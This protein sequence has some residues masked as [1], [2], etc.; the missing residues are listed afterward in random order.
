MLELA[1]EQIAMGQKAADKAEALRL[2][3]DRL[4]A[5]GLV[6]EGYLQGL[7]AREAQGSTFLGQ[8]IAIPHGTPQTRDLV[9]ATG[10]R[11]LQFPEGVDWGDGQMVYLAIGIAA[12]SDEHLRLLQLLTRALGETDLA[13]A[14]RRAGSAE[15]LLKLLQGAPQELALDAQL[16]GLNLA[17]EDFD[18]LAWRG[19]R[20]LQRA[21]C[22]DS[23][24][25]AVLQQAEPLPLGEG[26]WWLHSE[27]QVRQPGLAFITPQQPLRYRDQ[28]LNGLF[29]LASLGAAH[30][31]LLERLCEVLIEGRGQMLYQATSSRAVLEVLGGEA[32]ADWPS[33]RVVLANPHGLHARPAKVLAQLAKGFEGEIRVRLVDSAQ[34]A[35]SAKSLSKLLSLGARRGQALEL[36]AEPGIAADAL[37]VL[38]TAIEEGLG[39]EVEPLPQTAA[40]ADEVAE[41]LQAPGAGSR[42]QGV[43]AAPGIA[44]GPAHVCVEREFDYPLRGESCAQ[45][46]QK[47]REAV[48]TVNG[49]LQALIQR[50]DK[51]IGEIFIT[52]QEML[53]D[54]ALTDDVEQRLGQGESAAAAWMAVVEA[55]ARQQEA[56]HDALLA[57]RAADLRDIGRRVLAQ[58]CGVPAQAEPEQPYVL[59]MTEVGPSDVARLDPGRVAG[60]V[61]AQGGATAHSAIVARALG[62]PAVVGAGASILLLDNGT[63]LLLDGQRGVVSVAPP[64]DEL[65]RAL[66]ERDLREQRLQAAWA[67]RFE[68]AVT[69]DGHAVEVFANIGESNGIAKVV[70]QGA[71]GVGLL[72]TELIFMA[73]TQAP[74][75]ATQ[76]AE[77]RRVL[78]GLDG[79]PLV[80]RTLD[81][82]GD[83]PL[84][85]WPIAAEEN[86]FL[87]VRGVRLTLQRPQLMEDQLRALLRAAD[88]RPLRIMFPM[89]G[90]VHEWR[91]ARAM[92][93]RLRAEIPVA[94]LQL[95]IMVEVPSAALLAPQLAREVDF[96]SIGTNDLTQYTLAIDR[97]H[98]SL[99][100]QAD[101]L[102]PAVLSLIDMTVRAAH[103]HGKWVGV[104]GELAADPQAVAVLLGLDVDE[105]SVAA[106]S[107]AEV[108]ALVRQADYQTARA[109][110]HEA[111]QQDSAAAVR[112]LVERY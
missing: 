39:E 37:P 100:A 36:V 1:K 15:A 95:G 54:P 91:E 27:R 50:S 99:S 72:R 111:L 77:Y 58:L 2:L 75:V 85:Y 56:L 57:E 4:V 34:P 107:I 110:A 88:Q 82:G 43:G 59:V 83:K 23:G 13:E 79:R 40:V 104:C 46:R 16:V 103:A 66:A 19:A 48:A 10:V 5:D 49:E 112:A 76:E 80:V 92:V 98:P 29:C 67:N 3:A 68:P 81:V 101:G 105:L 71:E 78:D 30:Q 12:R 52:H 87:G 44:S 86:P 41:V 32:P 109:L 28:P 24:F 89:V 64:A 108:K 20:L 96:F 65:Q 47:L 102:H 84:P 106:R 74:D 90:Q 18:E 70:E 45:E 62:I 6:A 97:G 53:A 22:V 38:L 51:A 94:D 55:A 7:Q 35:V 42:I 11:L 17:A 73:H 25:A 60:I 93:E 21:D 9:Y 63:P 61:T 26:L 8:G 31:A 14:L 69:R 33:A